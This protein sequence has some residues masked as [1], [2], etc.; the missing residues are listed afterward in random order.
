MIVTPIPSPGFF[1]ALAAVATAFGAFFIWVFR[2]GGSTQQALTKLATC[3]S[4]VTALKS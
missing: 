4:D 1:E 3:K 2:V